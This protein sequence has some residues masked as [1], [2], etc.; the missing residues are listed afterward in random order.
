M[1]ITIRK[2]SLGKPRYRVHVRDDLGKAF[3]TK[4]YSTIREAQQYERKLKNRKDKREQAVSIS[5]RNIEVHNYLDEWLEY[6]ERSI[7]RGWY[8]TIKQSCRDYILPL[9]GGAKLSDIRAPHIGRV[10]GEMEEKGLRPSTRKIVYHILNQAFN[11][12]VDYFGYLDKNPVKKQ[13]KPKVHKVEKNFL[14][15]VEAFKLLEYAKDHYLGPALHLGILVGLRPSE[16]QALQWRSVDL[17]REQIL[18]C[19]A[20]KKSINKIEAHPKQKDWLMVPI[21][22]L[23]MSYLKSRKEKFP[24][25]FVAPALMGGML[26]QGKFRRGLAKLCREAGVGR[27]SPHELRHSCTE[28]WFSHG[29]SLEDVRRLLGHKCSKTT[30]TYVHRT[31]DRLI[32]LAKGI[33]AQL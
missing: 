7:S 14:K 5:R 17:E 1:A 19:A 11:D 32:K 8:R 30:Q 2:T 21:P 28:V 25:S 3:P 24:L 22:E 12:A 20:F 33:G 27:I 23:L 9:L 26:D 10:L 6:R 29:A 15:P 31:D 4:T 13:D 18:V 16:I